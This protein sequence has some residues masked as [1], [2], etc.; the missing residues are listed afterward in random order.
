MLLNAPDWVFEEI[1]KCLR[2][3]FWAGKEKSNG[4]QCLV[5]W[6]T[7]C[8]PTIF[9]GLGIKNIRKQALAL[10]VRWKWLRRVDRERP[11]QGIGMTKDDE[12][13]LVFNSMIKIVVGNGENVYF[14]KDRWIHGFT[15]SEIAPLISAMV[16]TREKNVRTM[17]QAIVDN[18]WIHDVQGDLSFMA[19]MQVANL[20]QA[21]AT[22]PIIAT[23]PDQFIWPADASGCYTAKSVY[24]RLCIGL[25]AS[26]TARC[27]WK[28]WAPLRYKIFAWLMVQYRLW[29]SDRRARHGLQDAPSACF[30]CL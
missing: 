7:V 30:T 28:S 20:C 14:W 19:H 13:S 6:D 23:A 25:L 15:I 22:V 18:A 17:Q 12:A 2:S 27:I 11:W 8:R 5:A 29:T 21:L 16:R 9:G 4:G 10:R 1:D 26:P 3:F 24:N